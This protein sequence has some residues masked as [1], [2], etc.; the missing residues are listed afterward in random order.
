[1]RSVARRELLLGL[2]AI[3]ALA[4][5][6]RRRRA[7]AR[8]AGVTRADV[9]RLIANC[10]RR[11]DAFRKTLDRALDRNPALDGTQREDALNKQAKRLENE[12]DQVKKEFNRRD[13]YRDIKSNVQKALTAGRDINLTMINR[14]MGGPAESDWAVLRSDLNA[15]ATVYGVTPITAR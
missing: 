11:S 15:L 8:A 9:S 2:V 14:K 12:L 4:Q 1:M 3:P 7:V 5:R 6:R 10:E 13:D